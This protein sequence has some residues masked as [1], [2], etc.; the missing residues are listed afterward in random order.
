VVGGTTAREVVSR[1]IGTGSGHVGCAAR[2]LL[3]S[4]DETRPLPRLVV[5]DR[6]SFKNFKSLRAVTI[7][8]GPLTV[9]VGPNGSGKSSVLLGMYLLSQLG[10]PRPSTESVRRRVRDVFT[11]FSGPLS[12][13]RLASAKGPLSL[14]LSMHERGG[15]ELLLTL[16]IPGASDDEPAHEVAVDGPTGRIRHASSARKP[17]GPAGEND[18]ALLDHPRVLRFYSI[19]YLHLDATVM[20]RTYTADEEEP[21]MAADGGGL[22]STLAWL[23]GAKPEVLHHI[24][25]GLARV[26]PGV[27]RILVDRK[28]VT[29][30]AMERVMIDGQPVWRPV[31]RTRL[32]DRF[33]IEFE[34]GTNVPAD[35]LSEGTVLALGLLTK[36]HEPERPRVLLL[37]DIDRGLHIGAQAELVAVLRDLMQHDPELQIVCTTHSAYLLDLFDPSEVR[38]LDLDASR[39]THAKPLTAHPDFDKWRFGTQTGELWAALGDAWVTQQRE[40]PAP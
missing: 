40:D 25:T 31:S 32:G 18:D 13:R 6:V 20:S 11:D 22:A 1:S 16:D 38:V 5:L 2:W 36:L 28:R 34:D 15:D 3:L 4:S 10:E 23:A 24:A 39:S 19:A 26:V 7:D 27:R 29:E 12:P 37:D 9:L 8:L 30:N 35:L 14:A 33:S 17:Q 21:R